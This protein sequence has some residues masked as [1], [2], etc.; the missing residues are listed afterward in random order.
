MHQRWV[1]VELVSVVRCGVSNVW[2]NGSLVDKIK[3][4]Q[5]HGF[6]PRVLVLRAVLYFAYWI[7]L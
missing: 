7:F 4:G 1:T 5:R 6:S 2:A 3:D